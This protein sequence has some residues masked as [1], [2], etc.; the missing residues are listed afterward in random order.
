[1]TAQTASF[2]VA[3]NALEADPPPKAFVAEDALVAESS[4]AGSKSRM[5]LVGRA[6]RA[7]SSHAGRQS[8]MALVGRA[9]RAR[10]DGASG[11]RNEKQGT[12]VSGSDLSG[13]SL[14]HV[15]EAC[16]CY[17]YHIIYMYVYRYIH[18]YMYIFMYVYIHASQICI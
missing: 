15:A 12:S 17:I 9:G 8:R 6:G 14:L 3:T 16:S 5:A 1:M 2:C 7:E 18:I 13:G 10:R 4:H 11:S